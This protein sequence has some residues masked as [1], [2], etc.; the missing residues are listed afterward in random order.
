MFDNPMELNE[1][2][3]WINTDPIIPFGKNYFDVWK[4]KQIGRCF[5]CGRLVNSKEHKEICLSWKKLIKG[6]EQK[7]MKEN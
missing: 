3:E 7:W 4:D 6:D 2:V 5:Y 1:Y